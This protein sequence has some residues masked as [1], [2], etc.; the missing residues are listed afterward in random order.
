MPDTVPLVRT[1]GEPGV[2][3]TDPAVTAV[4]S[5][6]SIVALNVSAVPPAVLVKPGSVKV[7]TVTRPELIPS[8]KNSWATPVAVTG[9]SDTVSVSVTGWG[10][11]AS[12][13]IVTVTV[14]G[15]LP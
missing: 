14:Y 3:V 4:W 11:V 15:L 8:V 10:V 2:T 1:P 7:A 5:P 13:L 12:W 9:G 6:Q